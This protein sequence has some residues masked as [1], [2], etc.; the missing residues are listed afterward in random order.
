MALV[1][2]AII[3][4]DMGRA[5]ACKKAREARRE[6]EIVGQGIARLLEEQRF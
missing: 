3:G 6:N 1:P 4:D 5:R 2:R